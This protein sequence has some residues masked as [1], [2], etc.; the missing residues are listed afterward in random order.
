MKLNLKHTIVCSLIGVG[1]IGLSSCDDFLDREPITN[2]TPEAYFATVDQVASYLDNYYNGH[3]VNSQ[4]QS[5]FHPTAWNAG[6]ANNDQNTDNLV[7]DDGS[8]TY[9]AGTWQASAGQ[10]LSSDYSKIRVWNYLI[11]TVL[12]KE[13]DG[14]ISGNSENL[15]HYIGEAYFFRAMAYY[16]A[17]VRL[18]DLPIITEV[19]P[20]DEVYLQENSVRAPRNEVARFILKDLDEAI[21]R[22]KDA[23]FQNN[24]R[25]NKQTAQLFKSRVALFEATFEK[26]HQ[27]TGRVPGDSNWPGGTF[28]GNIATEIDF[29]LSEAISAASAVA[30]VAVLTENSHQINPE[31]N[32]I[33]SWNPYFEMF[34]QPSLANVPEVLLWKE[35]N[36]SHNISHC[37]PNRLQLGDRSGITRSFITS[38][39]MK[40]GL[41]IYAQESGYKGDISIDLESEDRDERMQLFVWAESDVLKSDPTEASVREDEEVILFGKPGITN[42]AEQNRDLTGYRQRKHYTYDHNQKSGDELLGTNACPV[43]RSVEAMLNY[44]EAYYEKNNQLDSKAENYWKAIR[45]RAGVSEDITLTINSTDMSEEAKLND[46][47]VWSGSNMVDATLYNIRRERRCEFIGDGMRWDDLKRWRS[48]DRLFTQPYI[49]EGINLWDAAHNNYTGDEA[50][51]A[52]GSTSSNVSS[53]SVSKYVRTF[54]RWETNNQ[55]YNGYTWRKAYYLNPIG[56][57]ELKLAPSLYQ[58]PYWPSQSAG[59]AEE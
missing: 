11:N 9:F 56:I 5:L 57:E 46:L 41:P 17:L 3:L 43:F 7:K 20:N 8:L 10:T 33:Y 27:G 44:I 31:Y 14:S 36:K 55:L 42:G 16:N 24:Q 37:A 53:S 22:L 59:L 23:G 32:E 19:L 50:I 34:S 54:Q 28:N 35:Y 26:Y 15:K 51:V 4:G 12:P 45:Q 21:S 49:V 29:F 52:D 48:W 2:V 38:F 39:L 30:D 1:S 40:N 13:A 18:G 6:M 25:I 47:G 58:N